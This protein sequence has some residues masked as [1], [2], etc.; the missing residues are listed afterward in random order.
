M[1][2]RPLSKISKIL[3]SVA[4]DKQNLGITHCFTAGHFAYALAISQ[5]YV[6]H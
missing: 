1:K 2:E 3:M 5:L 6:A 4:K